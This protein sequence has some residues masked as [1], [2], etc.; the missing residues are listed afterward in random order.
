MLPVKSNLLPTVSKIFEDD[1][2]TIF[3]WTNRN[4][5]KTHTT[6]PSVN[7]VDEDDHLLIKMA[8]PGIDKKNI[9]IELKN[10]ILTISGKSELQ[11]E[12]VDEERLSIKEFNYSSFQRSFNLAE[13]HID[14][15]KIE[16]NYQN[17]ILS[18]KL[19]KKE[20]EKEI[21]SLQIPIK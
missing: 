3:D 17:G 5:K 11:N 16:A 10:D 20:E 7:V 4:F 14:K 21:A 1:W 19:E 12:E 6:L 2:N 8:V 18:V 13:S 9:N 15:Q